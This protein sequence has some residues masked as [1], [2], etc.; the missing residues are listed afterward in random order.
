MSARPISAETASQ[1]SS[2]PVQKMCSS[3][4][5]ERFPGF[6]RELDLKLSR[7]QPA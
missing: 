3:L 4:R 5:G 6:L 7:S 2:S 1:R